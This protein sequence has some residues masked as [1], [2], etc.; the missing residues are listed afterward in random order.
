[1]IVL[2]YSHQY[3]MKLPICYIHTLFFDLTVANLISGA[4]PITEIY[5]SVIISE[6]RTV[7]HTHN[8]HLYSFFCQNV[9]YPPLTR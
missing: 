4:I 8:C 9:K 3:C 5:I 6:V 1:M 7:F 2:I